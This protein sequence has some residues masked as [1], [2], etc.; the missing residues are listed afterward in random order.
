MKRIL[1]KRNARRAG[2]GSE[3]GQTA[4][5]YMLTISVLVIAISA[6]FYQLLGGGGRTPVQKSFD[7]VRSVVEH[8]YP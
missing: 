1:G 7:N 8:P 4:T 6:A 3:R 5:E 2:I